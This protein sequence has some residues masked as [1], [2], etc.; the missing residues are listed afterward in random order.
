MDAE[1]CK[2]TCYFK[3]TLQAGGTVIVEEL[4]NVMKVKN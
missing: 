3:S 1:S 2:I 4:L